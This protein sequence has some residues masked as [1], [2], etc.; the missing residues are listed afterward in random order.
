MFCE[1]VPVEAVLELLETCCCNTRDK[2]TI[3]VT[4]TSFKKML[5]H[6][7]H[8]AFLALCMPYYRRCHRHY[9]TRPLSYSSWLT[10]LRQICQS[11]DFT[12]TMARVGGTSE[13][14]ILRD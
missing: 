2:S 7:H 9:V 11:H 1:R 5:Y 8:T 10:I 4:E 12:C 3:V 13:L 6:K 14:H